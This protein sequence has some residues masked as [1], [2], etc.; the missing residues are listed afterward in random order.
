M[1]LT[2]GGK[3]STAPTKNTDMN[4]NSDTAPTSAMS[5]AN[6]TSLNTLNNMDNVNVESLISSLY[7]STYSEV[8]DGFLDCLAKEIAS[9]TQVQTVMI[10]RLLTLKE[11]QD[12]RDNEGCPC[13]QLVGNE[14]TRPMTKRNKSRETSPLV[15]SV[16]AEE[17][18]AAKNKI[19][20]MLVKA[21]Y[22]SIL[23]HNAL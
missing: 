10:Q 8:G 15:D 4:Y 2:L 12:L 13:I 7:A 14:S 9:I 22:S 19:E 23:D 21:C 17:E 1:N 20:Y 3:S 6:S 16:E 18:I 5:A 11:Y